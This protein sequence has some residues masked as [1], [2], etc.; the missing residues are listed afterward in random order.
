MAQEQIR[1]AYGGGD[2]RERARNGLIFESQLGNFDFRTSNLSKIALIYWPDGQIGQHKL[3]LTVFENRTQIQGIQES[4]NYYADSVVKTKFE[5]S[6][7]AEFHSIQVSPIKLEKYFKRSQIGPGLKIN[8]SG[9]QYLD[10]L[11]SVGF[12]GVFFL[13][14]HELQDLFTGSNTWLPSKGIFK[15]YRKVLVYHGLYSL[16]INLGDQKPVRKIGYQ[17]ISGDYF[18]GGD[19][20]EITD[21]N[22]IIQ[23]IK[24]RF[25]NN[26]DQIYQIH[27]L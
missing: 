5:S 8:E 6:S 24:I 16:L 22:E 23:Y 25:K 15:Y 27:K 14:E 4:F 17:Q 9:S 11:K 13:Y 12:D 19:P 10:S 7:V 1:G 21:L 3:G 2:V 26:I 18:E 20:K